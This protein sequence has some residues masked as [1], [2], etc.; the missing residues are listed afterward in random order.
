MAFDREIGIQP[1]GRGNPIWNKLDRLE[2]YPTTFSDRLLV[3]V[4]RLNFPSTPKSARK[5]S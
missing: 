3:I 5:V 1:S 4:I 2:A